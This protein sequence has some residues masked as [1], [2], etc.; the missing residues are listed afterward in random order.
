MVDKMFRSKVIF[1]LCLISICFNAY[2]SQAEPVSYYQL[3]SAYLNGMR[4]T[5]NL[6][7]NDCNEINPTIQDEV[8]PY[9]LLVTRFNLNTATLRDL[10]DSEQLIIN[11]SKRLPH[12]PKENDTTIGSF[13]DTSSDL[14][15]Y[16]S[17][18]VKYYLKAQSIDLKKDI[19]I[20]YSCPWSALSISIT[21]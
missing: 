21:N 12:N 2:S 9:S 19:N 4:A 11:Y 8:H 5:I 16:N 10:E 13:Y 20:L 17:E 15:L 7:I 6:N 18:Q 1:S 3:R 14:I